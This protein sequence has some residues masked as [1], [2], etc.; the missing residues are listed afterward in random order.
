MNSILQDVVLRG[1]G[2]KAL[3]LGRRDLAGKTGTTNDQKDAW[4]NGFHPDLVATA[5]VGFD[6]VRSLGGNETGSKAALPIWIDF[7]KVALAGVP[8]KS[9]QRPEGLVTMKINAETGAAATDLDKDTIFEI[10]R[11]ENVPKVGA[12]TSGA[13]TDVKTGESIPEQLF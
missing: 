5:W 10:F 12:V 6:Q 1:T 7:M 13:S 9:L 4:F 2:V 8:E 11:S 3:S